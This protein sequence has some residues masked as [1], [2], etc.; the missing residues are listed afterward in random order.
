MRARARAAP[1]RVYLQRGEG[2]RR[3][4]SPRYLHAKIIPQRKVESTNGIRCA[5]IYDA[6]YV[7]VKTSCCSNEISRD[8]KGQLITLDISKNMKTSWR[9]EFTLGKEFV[10]SSQRRSGGAAINHFAD[11]SLLFY[12]WSD[13]FVRRKLYIFGS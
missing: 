12:K 6:S 2:V 7:E 1:R 4:Y 5:R 11:I 13:Y 9:V 10:I 3:I 8:I